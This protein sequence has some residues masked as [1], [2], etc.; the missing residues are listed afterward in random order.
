MMEKRQLKRRNDYENY[1][2]TTSRLLLL[3]RRRIL[4]DEQLAEEK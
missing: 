2:K 4:D 3:P 1:R